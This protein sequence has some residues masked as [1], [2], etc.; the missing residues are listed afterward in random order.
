MRR[1]YDAVDRHDSRRLA[2]M[3]TAGSIFRFGNM[4]PV[5]GR[6]NIFQFLEGFFRS[7]KDIQHRNLEYWFADDRWFVT[8]DVK[9]RRHDDSTLE[10]PFAVLLRMDGELISEYRIFIDNHELYS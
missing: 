6:E 5:T 4:D 8:G 3:M 10:V 9:Y 2:G 1:I 7:I